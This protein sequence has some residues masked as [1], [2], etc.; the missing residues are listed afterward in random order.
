MKKLYML[1]PRV[2]YNV[3]NLMSLFKG[4]KSKSSIKE[5][6]KTIE[7][8]KYRNNKYLKCLAAQL[9]FNMSYIRYNSISYVELLEQNVILHLKLKY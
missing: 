4:G 9:M 6:G 7:V 5:V 8:S 3:L 2:I 1:L